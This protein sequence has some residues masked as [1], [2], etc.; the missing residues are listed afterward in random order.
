[1]RFLRSLAGLVVRLAGALAAVWGVVLLFDGHPWLGVLS[2]IGA[3]VV[4]V[5]GA[6][7]QSHGRRADLSNALYMAGDDMI[8]YRSHILR[9]H[10][11]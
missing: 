7:L 4:S 1:M 2:I 10:R 8:G 6:S 11:G 9:R 5:A 3:F